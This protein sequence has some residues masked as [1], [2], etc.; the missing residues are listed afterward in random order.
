MHYL[1][2]NEPIQHR[3]GEFPLAY[4][5]VDE[6]HP[7]YHMRMHWHRETELLWMRQGK[8]LLYIDNQPQKIEAG[9]LV[10]LGEGV[11]HGGE[12]Q[13]GIYECL[14]LD[15]YALLMHVDACKPVFRRV[16]G[17]TM[18]LQNETIFADP[19]FLSA[20]TR[21]YDAAG[22]GVACQQIRIVGALYEVFACLSEHEE[23]FLDLS[24]VQLSAKAEQIKPA[25]E[26]IEKNYAAPIRLETL[27]RLAGMS[28][29]YFCRCFREVVH[30]SPIDYVNYYRVE[31]ASFLLTSSNLTIAEIAQQCG[32]S[33]SSFFAKQ[34]RQYKNQTP[35]QYRGKI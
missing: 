7:R 5:R 28:P 10:V 18:I 34:F 13:D 35:R 33:D 27:A 12:A 22:R 17:R 31:C 29:K 9:D 2:Y 11:L 20:L 14:V 30:R 16:I 26:Y 8:L 6:H 4:Y 23:C 32:Y 15:P 21:L 24:A 3:T 1:E 25:L 19:E